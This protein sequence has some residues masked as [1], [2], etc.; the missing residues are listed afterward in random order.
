MDILFLSRCTYT[1]SSEIS[2]RA[3][4]KS[5]SDT[6]HPAMATRFRRPGGEEGYT[7]LRRSLTGYSIVGLLLLECNT[8]KI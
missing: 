1:P 6:R 8:I 7:E 2:R 4:T 5:G 3:P